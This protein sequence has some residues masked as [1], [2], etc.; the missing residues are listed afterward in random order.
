MTALLVENAGR[1]RLRQR[2]LFG[3]LVAS[4]T[5]L[6]LAV[7]SDGPLPGE[8]ATARWMNGNTPAAVDRFADLI[9]PALTDMAAPVVF[10]TI[11]LL[12]WWRWGRYP[13]VMLGLAGACTGLTRLGDLV[14]RPRPTPT[15]EWSGYSFGN[16]GYPSGHVVFSVLVLG[17]VALL[18]RR[19]ATSRIATWIMGAMSILI[20]VTSWT[21]V[22][23]LEHW[24]LD[25]VGGGLMAAAGLL[26]ISW[27]HPRLAALASRRPLLGRLLLPPAGPPTSST[28]RRPEED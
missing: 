1:W 13:A 10:V 2:I 20:A 23:R 18:A 5:A 9:D 28:N 8:V 3:A 24:P 14:Q 7:R 12:V 22:S 16:G 17:T 6:T 27:L 19:H 11:L 15:V 4:S 26:G 21:R 25:V